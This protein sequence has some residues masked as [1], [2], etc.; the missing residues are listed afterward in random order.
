M[1]KYLNNFVVKLLVYLGTPPNLAVRLAPV[2]VK[3]VSIALSLVLIIALSIFAVVLDDEDSIP[4]TPAY[5]VIDSEV[6][7]TIETLS[8]EFN[9]PPRLLAALAMAQTQAGTVSPYDTVVRG[10]A[11]GTSI[12]P[13]VTP[14][15]GS[16][17]V[18]SE[19]V[20]PYLL[21]QNVARR[22]SINAQ[23]WR[24]STIFLAEI[25]SKERDNLYKAG[26]R[27][28][29]TPEEL[30]LFWARI[31]S[32]LPVVDP[33]TG[34]S[35]CVGKEDD[36]GNSIISIFDCKIK[37]YGVRVPK[38]SL[39]NNVHVLNLL[40]EGESA[41]L[42][43]KDALSVAWVWGKHNGAT[44]WEDIALT[45]NN[46][47]T[48]AGVFPISRDQ[49]KIYN[50]VDRCDINA[51]I[52]AAADIVLSGIPDDPFISNEP[53]DV[54]QRGWL[55]LNRY[56][57][58]NN[59]S[60]SR[61]ARNG[62]WLDFTPSG[63]CA[64]A[65]NTWVTQ[66]L[67]KSEINE[68]LSSSKESLL[69]YI[70][71]EESYLPVKDPRC[72]D[73]STGSPAS[74][75]TYLSYMKPFVKSIRNEIEEGAIATRG[76]SAP[77]L[78]NL[79]SIIDDYDIK[80]NADKPVWGVTSSIKR[81]SNTLLSIEYPFIQSNGGNSF[82]GLASRVIGLAIE[83]GGLAGNDDRYGSNPYSSLTALGFNS[84]GGLG[85]SVQREDPNSKSLVSSVNLLSRL[86]CGADSIPRYATPATALR[87]EAMCQSAAR[88]GVNLSVVSAWRS[89]AQQQ[90]LYQ[91]YK[92]SNARVAKPGSSPHQKGQSVDV[93]LGSSDGVLQNDKSEY[94]WLHS[95]VG[96]LSLDDNTFFRLDNPVTN[97]EYVTSAFNGKPL[98]GKNILPIKRMQTFGF[99]PLCTLEP[100]TRFESLASEGALMCSSSTV[101]PG[102]ASNQIREPWH[103]DSGLLVSIAQG[104]SPSN[105]N[106]EIDSKID[107][108]NNKSLAVSI[109]EYWLCRLSEVGLNNQSPKGPQWYLSGK[110]KN[111]AEQV[112][113][114][115]VFVSFCESRLDAG[116]S[117]YGRKGLFGLTDSDF[118]SVKRDSRLWAD[119]GYNIV[120]GLE[121]WLQNASKPSLLEG[122]VSWGAVNTSLYDGE[123]HKFS[124]PVLGRFIA[125]I[126]SPNV[127]EYRNQALP[128]WATDPVGS[129]N[130]KL[131]C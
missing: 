116:F 76:N 96:C 103:L 14:D 49:A 118:K 87:W 105:N 123:S 128:D 92:G 40:S 77:V 33:I 120:T 63:N 84:I 93:Y 109:R 45:C 108:L 102:S 90:A 27:E 51:N 22:A 32:S 28:P 19:G 57:L 81:L 125:L 122:W 23:S 66:I 126:P 13:I 111:Y 48:L 2:I 117:K 16:S 75:A 127:G 74:F 41:G 37:E 25:L 80:I 86:V 82:N 38:V 107:V 101:I 15:I 95:V 60:I 115:A 11:S 47:K 18:R 131:K 104:N 55:D 43:V 7:T 69:N 83:F 61:F 97:N 71:G 79:I 56:V 42:L 31:I 17:K 3:I 99:V 110:F 30:D 88:D 113:S 94:A 129:W 68:N 12:F 1:G 6:R 130:A 70:N 39:I 36:V 124:I 58:G 72:I 89:M 65:T 26:V 73:A 9:I 121:L 21:K 10:V 50:V 35:G 24:E 85:V 78:D 54:M 8:Q 29:V 119:A 20:G 44:N 67:V 112:A 59:A 62:P 53:Y 98:C 52:N 34:G 100:V 4:S 91:S 114:E 46:S 5:E 106:C 64:D